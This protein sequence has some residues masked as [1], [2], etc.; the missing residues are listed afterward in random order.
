MKVISTTR[1]GEARKGSE[2]SCE[3]R[4]SVM[5]SRRKVESQ[6][7]R[8][9]V[10]R[11]K[12]SMVASSSFTS[13]RMLCARHRMG[14]R[15][16][17]RRWGGHACKSRKKRSAHTRAVLLSTKCKFLSRRASLSLGCISDSAYTIAC[18]PT[19]MSRTSARTGGDGGARAHHYKLLSVPGV[20]SKRAVEHS[21]A[22]GELG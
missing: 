9:N 21:R 12:P 4:T 8:R 14:E 18:H 19:W 2:A 17:R 22:A 10:A 7:A 15:G 16:R 6:P 5:S 13:L 3:R 20:D 1:D 11:P